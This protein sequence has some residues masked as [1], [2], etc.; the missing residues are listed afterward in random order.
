MRSSVRAIAVAV[1][2]DRRRQ[3]ERVLH[4]AR[5]VLRRHVQRVEAVPLVLGFRPLDGGEA[6]AR[7]DLLELVAHDGQRMAMAEARHPPRQRHVDGAGGRGV[8]R[9]LLVGLPARFDGDFQGVGVLAD[10]LLL[11]GRRAANQLH[12]RRDDAVLAS[13]IAVAQRL[14]L[15]RRTCRRDSAHSNAAMW[16]STASGL[17]WRRSDMSRGQV[18]G[19]SV[20]DYRPTPTDQPPLIAMR[21]PQP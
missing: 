1:A 9:R 18:A 15:R 10:V 7:E 4:V 2:A 21:E 16:A 20:A 12:P 14:A 3:V 17:G 19:D 6:H 5:G 8:L 13:E 11:I